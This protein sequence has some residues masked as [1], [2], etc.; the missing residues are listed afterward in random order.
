MDYKGWDFS[1]HV[2]SAQNLGC[3][4]AESSAKVGTPSRPG[5]APILHGVLS[6]WDSMPIE[7]PG[8]REVLTRPSTAKT[9]WSSQALLKGQPGRAIG[10]LSPTRGATGEPPP[11]HRQTWSHARGPGGLRL[12]T[13]LSPTQRSPIIQKLCQSSVR[14]WGNRVMVRHRT[15]VK[16]IA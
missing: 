16:H 4:P 5:L 10:F 13:T 9:F 6:A 15:P 12:Q 14:S 3:G 1:E 8:A 11:S 7:A 2:A